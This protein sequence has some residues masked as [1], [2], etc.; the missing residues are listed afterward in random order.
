MV[1]F[2]YVIQILSA[3]FL[4]LLVLL[5]SPKGD[6]MGGMMGSASQLFASQKTAEKGLNKVTYITGAVFIITTIVLGLGL[7]K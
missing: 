3:L 4:I 2:I 1:Q 6:G 5:H 7:I